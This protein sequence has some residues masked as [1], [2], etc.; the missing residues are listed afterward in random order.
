VANSLSTRIDRD[1]LNSLPRDRIA[2][3]TQAI[4]DP[5]SSEKGEELLAASATL[6]AVMV[7]RYESSPQDLYL[8]GK[9]VLGA[10]ED[11]HK[12]GNDQL[13]AL[14]DFAALR[15]RGEPII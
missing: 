14:R 13:E 11:F 1:V 3:M 9:R 12:K 6:F 4:L 2:G 10:E 15:V 7:E 8:Y 5:I